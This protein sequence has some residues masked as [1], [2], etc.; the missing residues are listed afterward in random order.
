VARGWGRKC[1]LFGKNKSR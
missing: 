1:P